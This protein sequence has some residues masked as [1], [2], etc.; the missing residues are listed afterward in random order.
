MSGSSGSPPFRNGPDREIYHGR[1]IRVVS[2]EVAGPDELRFERVVVRHPGAVAVVPLHGN[3][4]VT[5][6]RQ[7]R[8]AVGRA[9]LEAPAGTRDVTGEAPEATA[10]RE[11]AEEAG[12]EADHLEH[13]VTFYNSPGFCDQATVLY[14]ATGLRACPV[15]RGEFEERFMATERIHLG[16]VDSLIAAGELTDAQTLLGL[17]LAT[18]RVAAG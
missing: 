6:V 5:L 12:L 15:D 3:G 2:T 1:L 10:R 16:D 13:L 7:Y 11:L 18:Q 4:T 17:A 8:A 14:L 9:L